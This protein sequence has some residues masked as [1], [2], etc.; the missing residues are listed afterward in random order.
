[1][2]LWFSLAGCFLLF[3][4]SL[5]AQLSDVSPAQPRMSA[6]QTK[7]VLMGKVAMDSG[8]ASADRATIVLECAGQTRAHTYSDGEGSF[9]LTIDIVSDIPA[10]A[11]LQRETGV[12][13]DQEW[14]NCE[15]YAD[16]SGY[17]SE[18][19]HS[20]AGRDRGIVEVGTIVLHPLAQ[21]HSFVV[22]VT[23]LA[24]PDNARKAFDKGREQEQKGKWAAACDYFK[25]AVAVYPRYALAWME[26]GR[27]QVK[28]NSFLEAQQSFRQ[29]ITQDA[30]LTDG[31]AELARLALLQQQWKELADITDSLLQVSPDSSAE[32]WFLNS[33][34]NFNLGNMKQA[35]TSIGHG[36]GLDPKH[37]LSQMEYLYALI[38]ARK[39]D[40]KSAAE[41]VSTYLRLS[42][43]AKDAETAQKAL[44]DFEK[45]AQFA[46]E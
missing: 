37:Q 17:S 34:A 24:A 2:K 33:A 38:L 45:R 5:L 43:H 19:V 46:K 10:A 20:F 9:S 15:L 44:A 11:H 3:P 32:Y 23:S 12:V 35:E 42:P 39:Q 8:V 14:P 40:Y 18:R 1:M 28:Q 7:A 22:S 36:L 26:L 4:A 21:D 29:A 25:R 16:L 13:S 31:Y 6:N 30:K 27:A 41:H